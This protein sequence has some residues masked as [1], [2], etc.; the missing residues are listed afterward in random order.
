MIGD[1]SEEREF[2]VGVM[3]TVGDNGDKAR[4]DKDKTRNNEAGGSRWWDMKE[5]KPSVL[6]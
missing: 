2:I 1:L 3:G 4:N 5:L 6:I